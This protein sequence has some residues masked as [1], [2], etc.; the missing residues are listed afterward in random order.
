MPGLWWCC[1]V[2]MECK[3]LVKKTRKGGQRRGWDKVSANADIRKLHLRCNISV[4][5]LAWRR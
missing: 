4:V 1:N 2:D 3:T 5:T